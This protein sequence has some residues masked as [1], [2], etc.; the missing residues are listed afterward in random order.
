M[1][2]LR[3]SKIGAAI[4]LTIAPSVPYA[5][6]TLTCAERIV[7]GK[8][9]L[10]C[11]EKSDRVIS[12]QNLGTIIALIVSA[13]SVVYAYKKDQRARRQSIDDDY[14][15]RS[16]IHPVFIEPLTK[17]LLEVGSQLPVD[18]GSI[19][20]D[21]TA[22]RDFMEQRQAEIQQYIDAA[23]TL[24]VVDPTLSSLV[25]DCVSRAEDELLNYCGDNAANKRSST[26]AQRRKVDAVKSLRDILSEIFA[27]LRTF[28]T[29]NL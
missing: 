21:P 6:T 29:K 10:V 20:W 24:S 4:L 1:T 18:C 14:W 12:F 2:A 26:G 5:A 27:A 3:L 9:L 11:Q 25:I 8:Q 17:F 19:G 28:Q 22:L 15:I 7:A 13:G 16:V 23:Y